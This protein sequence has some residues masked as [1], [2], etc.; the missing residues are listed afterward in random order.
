MLDAF[1]QFISEEQLILPGQR[2]LIAVS[3]GMDSICMASLFVEAGIDAGIVHCNFGLRGIASDGD[4]YFVR[5][6]AANAGL[7]FYSK[8]F[9]T[10]A[11]ANSKGI[12]IQMAARDLR[13]T[14]FDRHL[15]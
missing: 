2:V 12:S 1:R 4:E 15:T 5:E 6:W 9:D 3:G 10:A 7:P 11:E 13:Y 8:Q 14:F